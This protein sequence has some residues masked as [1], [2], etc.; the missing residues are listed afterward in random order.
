MIEA[1]VIHIQLQLNDRHRS[2][3]IVLETTCRLF[4]ERLCDLDTAW[5]HEVTHDAGRILTTINRARRIL[6]EAERLL[7]SETY[8]EHDASQD[9][10]HQRIL[11]AGNLGFLCLKSR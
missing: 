10:L 5:K 8:L 3:L 9:L 4:F 7:R 2:S 1:C 6:D 11:K